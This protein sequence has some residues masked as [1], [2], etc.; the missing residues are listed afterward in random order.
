YG[1]RPVGSIGDVGVFAFYPNKQMTTGEGGLIVTDKSAVAAEARSL[2]NQGRGENHEWLVH[3]RLG[4]NYRITEMSAALG[5][6]QF[7]R[8]ASLL[9]ARARV[10]AWYSAAL[11]GLPGLRVPSA[12]AT[13][14]WFVYVVTLDPALSRDRVA[15][16]LARRGI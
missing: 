7:K 5:I 12:D 11:Q 13:T 9:K 16:E 10:A 8:L 2:R 6:A 15:A 14:S 4:Y 1:G 3:I